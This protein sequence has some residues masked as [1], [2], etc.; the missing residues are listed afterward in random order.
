MK[1][2]M[3]SSFTITAS[4][5]CYMVFDTSN[6][7]NPKTHKRGK[8]TT[9]YWWSFSPIFFLFEIFLEWGR[10]GCLS[11]CVLFNKSVV[12]PNCVYNKPIRL[13]CH[14]HRGRQ[15]WLELAH[16]CPFYGVQCSSN[17]TLCPK[18]SWVFEVDLDLF[19]CIR[20]H[21]KDSVDLA[22]S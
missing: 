13:W 22:N 3:E 6:K 12:G 18:I 14:S 20:I 11:L 10:N 15:V 9:Y 5:F 17:V 1:Q 7:L 8:K 16:F 4:L 2:E 21:R 19:V